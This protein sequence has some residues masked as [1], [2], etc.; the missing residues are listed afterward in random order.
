MKAINEWSCALACVT[1][2]LND[3]G[4]PITQENIVGRFS[5]HFPEW[6]FRKGLMSQ[7][8]ILKLIELFD[9]PIRYFLLTD[10][11]EEFLLQFNKYYPPKRYLCSFLFTS[12]NGFH[13]RR[14]RSLSADTAD[15][16]DISPTQSTTV[17]MTWDQIQA[18]DPKFLL[19]CQ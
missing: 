10:D 3:T 2:F 16:M 17:P 5:C 1:S 8:D 6:K 11:K 19:L 7:A 13:C 15:V 9:I 18:E 14:F 4:N 12:K